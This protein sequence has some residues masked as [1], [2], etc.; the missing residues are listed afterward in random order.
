MRNPRIAVL[1]AALNLVLLVA[2]LV[3][4]AWAGAQNP[5]PLLAAGH[6]SSSTSAG[7]SAHGST[8]SPMAGGVSAPG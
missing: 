6:S 2:I 4:R 8:W 3:H 1:V 7:E 5:A